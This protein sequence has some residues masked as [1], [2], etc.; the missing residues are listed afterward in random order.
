MVAGAA[1]S[2]ACPGYDPGEMVYTSRPQSESEAGVFRLY[3][4]RFT[5]RAPAAFRCGYD[6]TLVWIPTRPRQSRTAEFP[7]HLVDLWSLARYTLRAE[8][9]RWSVWPD[10]NRRP[11]GPEPSALP[12]A[13][14]T[15]RR[16]PSGGRITSRS[17]SH[18]VGLFSQ[19]TPRVGRPVSSR[20]RVFTSRPV[21]LIP[22]TGLL[23][24]VGEENSEPTAANAL[25]FR[26]RRPRSFPFASAVP[27]ARVE[28]Q[29]KP[30]WCAWRDLN[31]RPTR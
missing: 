16:V 14:Q 20:A 4:G 27:R 9:R 7:A 23:T 21:A 13:L 26:D 3:R 30:T 1:L 8:D 12:T 2:A 11:L 25:S 28:P 31:P 29:T 10:L 18:Q 19:H 5:R 17:A 24:D 6:G 15:E 22:V